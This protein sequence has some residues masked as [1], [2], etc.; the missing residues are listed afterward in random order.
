MG[1]LNYFIIEPVGGHGGMNYYNTG[2]GQGLVLNNAS[3]HLYT[4]PESQEQSSKNFKINKF[5]KGVYGK[6]NKIIRL[7]RFVVA[8][9]RSIIDIKKKGGKICHLHF[10][11][12]SFLELI[13]CNLLKF[14]GI[15]IVA[16]VHDVES[17]SGTSLTR[18]HTS[19]LRAPEEFIVHN[20]FSRQELRSVISAQG[21]DKKIAI[22]PHGN[23]LP[24]VKRRETL[25]S[26]QHLS[27]PVDKKLIL[28]FGQIKK[29][30]GLDILLNAMEIVSKL[31]PDAVLLIA[32][33][34]WKDSFQH[35][36]E[37][38]KS[39][40]ISNV[41]IPHIRYINDEDV[42]FYYSSAD[43]VV[44]PYKKIY[45]SGV[46]LMAMSYGCITVSSRLPAM[47]EVVDENK[48]GFLFET[49][50]PQDLASQI[51]AALG[52]NVAENISQNARA[53]MIEKHDWKRVA[54]LHIKVFETYE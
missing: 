30:K 1:H 46:L 50:N 16:T 8:L 52:S 37:L 41:V 43:V 25:L 5:F 53:A 23:Y 27:L 26:R 12:Y 29:V 28:F 21:I 17:F 2:L 11:Q 20:E 31:E 18:T 13:T 33:K 4:C 19:I 44:L 36:E 35:Y 10:F 40:N 38:I 51:L 45:Q 9:T 15:K 49:D 14:S 42:D 39:K 47:V 48:N 6:S 24:F 22:I 54:R 7:A 3:V 34:V 32:G